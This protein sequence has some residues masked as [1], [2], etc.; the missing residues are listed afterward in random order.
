[1]GDTPAEGEMVRGFAGGGG[2]C[3]GGGRRGNGFAGVN[4]TLRVLGQMINTPNKY[5]KRK[6]Q[7]GYK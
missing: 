5:L 6:N 1:M 7:K 3:D 4:E 2:G